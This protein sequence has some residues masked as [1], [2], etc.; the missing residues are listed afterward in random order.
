MYNPGSDCKGKD[1]HVIFVS[2]ASLRSKSDEQGYEYI[3]LFNNKA[4]I[5]F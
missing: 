1:Y 4:I 2:R 5:V 3:A